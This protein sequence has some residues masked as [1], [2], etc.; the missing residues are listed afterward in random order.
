MP[1][2]MSIAGLGIA[3]LT[4]LIFVADLAI[5]IPFGRANMTMDIG[6]ATAAAILGYLSFSAFRDTV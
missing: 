4:L 2:A 5:G 6:F 1:K 3:G